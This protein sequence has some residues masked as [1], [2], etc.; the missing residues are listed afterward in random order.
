[1]RP[2]TA[3]ASREGAGLD[4]EM[5]ESERSGAEMRE[6]TS[7]EMRETE[8]TERRGAEMRKKKYG[9]FNAVW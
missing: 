6:R 4:A 5:R 7:T 8:S 9:G 1:M 3:K 2:M